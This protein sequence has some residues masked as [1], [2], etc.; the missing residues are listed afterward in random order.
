M[1]MYVYVC[2][3]TFTMLLMVIVIS[4]WRRSLTRTSR[5]ALLKALQMAF[6]PPAA[7]TLTKRMALRYVV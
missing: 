6:K 5:S 3:L 1:Y 2:I 4:R 7:L